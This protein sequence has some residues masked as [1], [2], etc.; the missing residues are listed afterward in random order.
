MYDE[1]KA[2]AAHALGILKDKEAIPLLE[3]TGKA[4]NRVLRES[5]LAAIKKINT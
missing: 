3:K 2:C 4:K 1:T 5:S